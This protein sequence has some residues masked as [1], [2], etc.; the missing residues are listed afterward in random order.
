MESQFHSTTSIKLARSWVITYFGFVFCFSSLCFADSFRSHG[1]N[2]Y[3]QMNWTFSNA[4]IKFWN[5][6]K[7]ASDAKTAELCWTYSK[8]SSAFFYQLKLLCCYVLC[9]LS[10][11]YVSCEESIAVESLTTFRMNGKQK[12]RKFLSISSIR[13]K[14]FKII[15]TIVVTRKEWN[16]QNKCQ[17]EMLKVKW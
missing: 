15:H 12:K 8:T 13:R 3:I 1:R 6:N 11:G 2:Q 16:L 9:C 7:Y 14:I 17:V 4:M 10:T 5:W